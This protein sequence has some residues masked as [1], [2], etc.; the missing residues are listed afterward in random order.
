MGTILL[1]LTSLPVKECLWLLLLVCSISGLRAQSQAPLQLD[2]NVSESACEGNGHVIS[3]KVKGGQAPYSYSWQDGVQ[4][5]FRKDLPSGTYSCTVRDA[6]G[7]EASKQFSFQ[8]QPEAIEL[9]A[10]QGKSENGNNIVTIE[11]KGGKA[12]YNYLWIGSGID[13][14]ASRGKNKQENLPTGVYQIVVQDANE[15]ATSIRVNVQ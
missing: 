10:Q 3:I 2:A 9:S 12:P 13:L 7:A 4:G 6:S 5:S 14:K 15:C 1:R 11:V 8:P